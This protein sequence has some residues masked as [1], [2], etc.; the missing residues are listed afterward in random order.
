MV[1]E[2]IEMGEGG[3]LQYGLFSEWY[4]VGRREILSII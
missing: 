2:Q 4:H 1:E 3:A